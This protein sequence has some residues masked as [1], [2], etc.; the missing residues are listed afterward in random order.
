MP[1][2]N[3]EKRVISEWVVI[4]RSFG[5]EIQ[6]LEWRDKPHSGDIE[7]IAFPFAIEHTSVDSIKNQRLYEAQFQNVTKDLNLI[8]IEPPARIRLSIP[9]EDFIMV[10]HKNLREAL[11]LWLRNEASQLPDGHTQGNVISYLRVK[12]RCWKYSNR[13]PGLYF[14]LAV[15]TDESRN[16]IVDLLSKKDQKL[17]TYRRRGLISVVIV[18]SKDLQMMAAEIFFEMAI[19]ANE[20][21]KLTIGQLWFADTSLINIEFWEIDLKTKQLKGPYSL[22]SQDGE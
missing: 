22:T 19:N 3:Q 7:A 1:E 14:G 2:P 6:E 5:V 15:D 18:E 10:N 12:W 11:I 17:E 20:N 4:Q 21:N 8:E 13:P 16:E 9:L